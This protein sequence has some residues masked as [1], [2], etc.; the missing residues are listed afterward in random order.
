LPVVTASSTKLINIPSKS[1][2]LNS[3]L[4]LPPPSTAAST[5]AIG[6]SVKPLAPA[7]LPAAMEILPAPPFA[8]PVT[9]NKHRS[10]SEDSSTVAPT[11]TT[12]V[13]TLRR[14]HQCPFCTKSCERKDNLQA[15]I[16][17]HTGAYLPHT[18]MLIRIGTFAS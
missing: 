16:R 11:V 7:V 5:A 3:R 14:R 4:S 15:H 10:S 9:S 13:S 1:E 18:C 17:T 8:K 2:A 12:A 6:A